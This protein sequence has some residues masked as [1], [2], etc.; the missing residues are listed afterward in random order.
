MVG[1]DG[2]RNGDQGHPRAAGT[3]PRVLSRYVR[4]GKLHLSEAI[5]KMTCIPAQRMGLLHKG[6]LQPGFDAD[7]VIFDPETIEDKATF[8]S[9]ALPPAGIHYVLIGGEIAAEHGQLVRDDLGRSLRF[10]IN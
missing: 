9:P 7:I 4:R 6:S 5:A 10:G 2:L 8:E 1:S 3:F